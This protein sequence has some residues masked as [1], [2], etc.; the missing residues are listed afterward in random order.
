[1][2]KNCEKCSLTIKSDCELYTVCEGNCAKW[3]HADCVGITETDLCALSTNIIWICD[4][5]MVLFCRMREKTHADATTNTESLRPIEDE[6]CDLKRTVANIA[7]TLANVILKPANP[8]MPLHSTPVSSPKSLDG[9]NEISCRPVHTD[10]S[11]Y[12]RSTDSHTFAMYLSNIDKCVTENDIS[13]MVSRTL[14][15]PVSNCYDVVKLVS[16]CRNTTTLDYVSFK[17][18]LNVELKPLALSAST[19][20]KQI[21]FREFVNRMNETW[22]P[23]I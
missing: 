8:S 3:F 5:C 4:A 21:K 22:K 7:D 11:N 20:P 9:T 19:W 14:K 2:A 18:V 16:K 1:M 17:V 13:V 15:T 23:C 6:I 12:S 10:S